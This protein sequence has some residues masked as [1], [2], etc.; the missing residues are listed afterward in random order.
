MLIRIVRTIFGKKLLEIQG[1]SNFFFMN[2]AYCPIIGRGGGK[3]LSW[4]STP[5]IIVTVFKTDEIIKNFGNEK[6]KSTTPHHQKC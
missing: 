6:I 5:K 2:S 3:W 4:C 1:M